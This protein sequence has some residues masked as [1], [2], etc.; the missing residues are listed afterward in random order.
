MTPFVSIASLASTSMVDLAWVVKS[1]TALT[2]LCQ[3]TEAAASACPHSLLD[4][5]PNADALL[6]LLSTK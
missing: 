2:A 1:N 6:V 3:A 4:S 5:T